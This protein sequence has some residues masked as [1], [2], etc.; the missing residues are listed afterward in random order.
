MAVIDPQP[1]ASLADEGARQM[2]IC[3]AC[4]YCEGYCAVFPAMERRLIFDRHDMGYLAN[5][6][7]ACGECYFACQ[8]AP[9]HEFA[10]NIPQVLAQVRTETYRDFAWPAV[11]AAAFNRN[12]VGTALTLALCI[13]GAMLAAAGFSGV[14]ILT[15][16]APDGD[17]FKVV[18]HA[19]M[20]GTFGFVGLF[21]LAALVVG[22]VKA[23][24]SLGETAASALRPAAWGEAIADALTLKYLSGDGDGCATTFLR[25]SQARRYAHHL[26]FYGFLLCFASTIAGTLYHYGFGWHAPYG[27]FS[28]PVV[29]GT[30]GGIGLVIGPPLLAWERRR[31]DAALFDRGHDRLADALIVLLFLSGLTGLG[32]LVL[33]GT[34]AMAVM[35]LLHLA[36]VM[37]LFLTIP[38]GKFV[39]P[40]YRLL[41]LAKYALERRRPPAHTLGGD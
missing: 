3:N 21:V 34:A 38:Y 16:T 32:L 39:H 17:F 40:L 19:V 7:H 28:L 33:R 6:C 5:L 13:A 26:T 22:G 14:G 15:L 29:L 27:L 10:V 1:A 23:W 37:A 9:P 41:A 30:L 20:A 18:P 2:T 35:L 31:A 11:I 12:A 25:R 4:R 24:R 36:V 8:F